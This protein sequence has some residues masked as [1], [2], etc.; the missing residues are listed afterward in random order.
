MEMRCYRKILRISYKIHVT[1]Q[2]IC[3]KI[4]QAI[5]QHKA[6]LTIVKRH[7]LQWSAHVSRSS[8]LAKTTL[9]GTMKGGA[10]EG[11]QNFWWED[12]IREWTGVEFVKTQRAVVNR[13]KWEETGC[14]VNFGAPTIPA[15][16]G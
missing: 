2:K 15:V 6:L 3:A 4:Q 11:R 13:K 9:Q 5:G 14:E 8:D 16:K 7:K 12:N 1:N 10:R